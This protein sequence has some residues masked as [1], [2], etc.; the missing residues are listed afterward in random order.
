MSDRANDDQLCTALIITPNALPPALEAALLPWEDAGQLAQLHADLV[1][2]HGPRG[3]T[4]RHLVE[5]LALLIWRKRRVPLAERALH[6][7]ALRCQATGWGSD[8]LV[9][10]ALV[11]ARAVPAELS[12][13]EALRSDARQDARERADLEADAALTQRALEILGWGGKDA[14]KRAV[15]ALHPEMRGWWEEQLETA[16]GAENHQR[17]GPTAP[18]LERFLLTEVAAA[19]EQ[20]GLRLAAQEAVRR[21][22][23][24]QSLDPHRAGRLQLYDMHLDRQFERALALLLKLQAEFPMGEATAPDDPGATKQRASL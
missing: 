22:A 7:A 12:V 4:E 16:E 5:Q 24:G 2:E 10:R 8:E 6:L 17:Y 13:A 9:G 23:H 14:Y 15:A 21:Q 1:A 11:T 19:D 18:D 20:A 3:P